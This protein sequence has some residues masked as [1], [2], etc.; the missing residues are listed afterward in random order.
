[1]GPLL[2]SGGKS[3][4]CG[5]PLVQVPMGFPSASQPGSRA[6]CARAR[7]RTRPIRPADMPATHA[8][9]EANRV[10]RVPDPRTTPESAHA[11]C[12]SL[13]S[14]WWTNR[15]RRSQNSRVLGLMANVRPSQC[16]GTG[17]SSVSRI[18]FLMTRASC[19][20]MG[21]RSTCRVRQSL[22]QRDLRD[23]RHRHGHPAPDRS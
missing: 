22:H 23:P 6:R 11:S 19:L 15:W 17:S 7:P 4:Q 3:M 16:S 20:K 21:R 5:D 14:T 9:H 13:R 2:S 1:M 18:P 8:G 12:P 10:D